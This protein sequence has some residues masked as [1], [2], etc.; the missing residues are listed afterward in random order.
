VADERGVA[1]R[2]GEQAGRVARPAQV[3]DVDDEEERRPG[4]ESWR[5]SA[6]AQPRVETTDGARRGIAVGGHKPL[7]R[8]ITGRLFHFG[9]LHTPRGSYF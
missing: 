6:Q 4:R 7:A 8:G 5:L 3:V 2:E 1:D 9:G